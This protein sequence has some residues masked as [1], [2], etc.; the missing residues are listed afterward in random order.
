MNRT[1]QVK[2]GAKEWEY[3]VR[4]FDWS[5][6]EWILEWNL[7]SLW[8]SDR[9][10]HAN[11]N[12]KVGEMTSPIPTKNT[13]CM[14]PEKPTNYKQKGT[15]ILRRPSVPNGKSNTSSND[16]KDEWHMCCD[17]KSLSLD[18]DSNKPVDDETKL[19]AHHEKNL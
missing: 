15:Q 6:R 3:Y 1:N 17:L 11:T 4:V 8:N 13:T 16:T 12:R 9:Y 7:H 18:P 2:E 10:D 14:P 5:G 19:V